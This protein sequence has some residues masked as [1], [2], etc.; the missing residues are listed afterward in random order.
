MFEEFTFENLMEIALNKA[1]EAG[2]DTRQGSVFYD[3]I[4]ATM[5]QIAELFINADIIR[6]QSFIATA[7]GDNLDM[8]A[9]N[10]YIGR[11]KREQA[12][13]ALYSI[14]LKTDEDGLIN[15]DNIENVD[16]EDGD[17]FVIDDLY[18]VFRIEED[19]TFYIEAE[20]AGT[21]YNNI[22]SGKPAASIDAEGLSEANI[23][24]LIRAGVDEENDDDFRRRIQELLSAPSENANSSQYKSWCENIDGV[25][26][27]II[28]PLFAGPNTVKAVL[29]D[30]NNQPCPDEVISLVQE[31]IDPI[32]EHIKITVDDEEI[33]IG[34]GLGDGLAPIGAHFYAVSAPVKLFNIYIK[35]LIYTDEYQNNHTIVNERIVK[36]INAY[37]SKL[38]KGS[39]VTKE[40]KVKAIDI[41]T[42]VSQVNGVDDFEDVS[43]DDNA[44]VVVAS[45]GTIPKINDIIGLIEDEPAP[46]EEQSGGEQE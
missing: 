27:A 24:Y 34:D 37:F 12:V 23:D 4:A 11:I 42:I 31:T 18:F 9:E 5:E 33:E 7:T 17:R 15:K 45:A 38:V 46:E 26:T 36:E 1:D 20:N 35:E 16:I 10:M 32:K 39:S 41:I 28:F 22:I 44:R 14:T 29:T 13:T 3:A 2:V 19:G 43:F 8:L 30:S 25:G 40:M 21:E 6:E